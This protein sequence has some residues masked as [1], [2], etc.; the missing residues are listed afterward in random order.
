[1]LLSNVTLVES[2]SRRFL[3]LGET[4]LEGLYLAQTM[5]LIIGHGKTGEAFDADQ[6]EVCL[7]Q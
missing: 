2:G 5:G 3:Q 6:Y 1:M 7:L 4:D